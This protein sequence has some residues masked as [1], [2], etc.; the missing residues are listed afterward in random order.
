[1]R[2]REERG[3][4]GERESMLFDVVVEFAAQYLLQTSSQ[5]VC[6]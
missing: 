2:E 6:V 5:K 4:E 3:R 1:M